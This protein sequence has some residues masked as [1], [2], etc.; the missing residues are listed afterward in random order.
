MKISISRNWMTCLVLANRFV[1]GHTAKMPLVNGLAGF[2]LLDH[3]KDAFIQMFMISL[4]V[5]N[6]SKQA[7]PSAVSAIQAPGMRTTKTSL[8]AKCII[9]H[10][11]AIVASSV[12]VRALGRWRPYWFISSRLWRTSLGRG[13]RLVVFSLHVAHNL[14]TRYWC[15]AKRPVWVQWGLM[16]CADKIIIRI[17]EIVSWQGHQRY[18]FPVPPNMFDKCSPRLPEHNTTKRAFFAFDRPWLRLMPY[19]L[20]FGIWT[21]KTSFD[22]R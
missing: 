14:W 2:L 21:K 16:A 19:D 15:E 13:R 3:T 22:G 17:L 11:R 1:I 6:T 4:C 8:R 20:L 10:L 7:L 18:F 5:S 9:V 12:F